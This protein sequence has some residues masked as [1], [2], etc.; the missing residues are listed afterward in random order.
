LTPA[1]ILTST[2]LQNPST[3]LALVLFQVVVFA[4]LLVAIPA[5]TLGWKWES[6]REFLK[7]YHTPDWSEAYIKNQMDY[8]LH[9]N[10]ANNIIFVG[11]ST[12]TVG[13]QPV[14]FEKMTG[15]R[16][17]NLALP[18]FVGIDT[19]LR[20]IELYLENHPAP[21]LLVYGAHPKD[22]GLDAPNWGQIRPRFAWSYGVWSGAQAT[23]NDFTPMYYVREGIR[24]AAGEL[25]GGRSHYFPK[26][27]TDWKEL[28]L[29]QRGFFASPGVLAENEKFKPVEIERF[30]VSPW[31]SRHLHALA[32]LTRKHG[33]R[34]MIQPTP[35]MVRE[36]QEDASQLFAWLQAFQGEYP[37]IIVGSSEMLLYDAARFS[38]P[39]HMNAAGASQFTSQLAEQIKLFYPDIGNSVVS[40]AAQ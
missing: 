2:F 15:L 10:E 7:S 34:L 36:H 8:V 22:Y 5:Y 25:R 38:E 29:R 20:L 13:I 17:Y 24:I 21:R 26:S 14:L 1:L 12:T 33:I 39:V 37:H 9:S 18:G 23:E 30:V 27:V 3:R 6:K 31:Y 40:T 11:D 28:V 32:Q 35:V 16:G 19:N 4:I